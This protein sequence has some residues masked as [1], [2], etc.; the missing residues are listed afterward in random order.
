MQLNLKKKKAYLLQFEKCFEYL[1]C[2]KTDCKM[3]DTQSEIYCWESEAALCN[4][5]AF[6]IMRNRILKK[7]LKKKIICHKS[8]C[9]YFQAALERGLTK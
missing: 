5:K 2:P 8:G 9:I 6:I 4:H 1:G 3:H 7:N